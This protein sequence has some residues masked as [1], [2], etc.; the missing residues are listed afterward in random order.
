MA[1]PSREKNRALQ[2]GRAALTRRR[3]VRAATQLFVRDGYL[4]TT[5]A[6]I[7][8]AAGVAVRTVYLSFGSKV[9]V[10]VAALDVAIAGDDDPIPV[11]DRAWARRLI[12]E[13]DGVVALGLFAT[14]ASEIIERTYPLYAVVQD[15]AADPELAEVL[16]RNKRLRFVTHGHVASALADKVGFAADTSAQRAVEMI[17]TLMSHETYR[18]LVVE[19]DWTV[20]DW[21]AWVEY[22]LRI[23]LFPRTA[24]I[25]DQRP[26][27]SSSSS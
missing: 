19:H 18:L 23:D 11:L 17:Y 3:V 21:S 8:A 14:A 2:A 4:Q 22:H 6:G 27:S 7:A 1:S 5:I 26:S 16:D 12:E 24:D 10:L 13:P 9:E 20:A 25:R 15:G